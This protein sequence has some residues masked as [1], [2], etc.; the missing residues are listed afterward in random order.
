VK[1]S[2]DER[3]DHRVGH[4]EEEYPQDV[5]VL[6]LAHVGERVYDEDDLVGGPADYERS[7]DYCRHAQRLHLR[8]GEQTTS[9]G[10]RSAPA[11]ACVT[12]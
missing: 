3:V 10:R 8:L 12:L 11:A 9:N 2:V 4:A 7:H 5:A 1:R 6:D